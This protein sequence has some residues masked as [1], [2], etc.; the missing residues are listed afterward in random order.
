[1]A[2][3]RPPGAAGLEVDDGDEEEQLLGLPARAAG[4]GAGGQQAAGAAVKTACRGALAQ[5]GYSL[6]L[7]QLCH[8]W[9]PAA[10]LA[11]ALEGAFGLPAGANLYCTPGGE[12]SGTRSL[13][14]S[15]GPAPWQGRGPKSAHQG[16]PP[17]ECPP[18]P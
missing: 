14:R 17:P 9:R 11:E 10:A 16:R 5:Q 3:P 13:V 6:A 8:R 12:R 7:R 1:M 2:A 4:D 18:Y 15:L